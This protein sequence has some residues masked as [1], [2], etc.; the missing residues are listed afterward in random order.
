MKGEHAVPAFMHL[1]KEGWNVKGR[2][3]L[4]WVVGA[5]LMCVLFSGIQMIAGNKKQ[6]PD[7]K[8][9]AAQKPVLVWPL[10]PDLPRVRWL[11]E[12]TDMARVDKPAAKKHGWLDKLTGARTPDEKRLELQKPY[13]ITTDSRGRMYVA[14]TGLGVVFRVDATARVVDLLGGSTRVPMRMPVGVATDAEDRLFVS[15]ALLHSISCFSAAG[16]EIANFG[17]A[18]LG[19]PGGIAIDRQRNRLYAADA[20]ENRIAVFDIRKFTLLGY[21]GAMNSPKSSAEGS[22]AGPTNVAVDRRG[23]IYVADTLNCRIQ[24]LDPAG[25]I[26]RVF[27]TQGDRPGEFI[28]PKGIALD[29]EGHVYVADAEFNNFQIFSP[30]GHP[31]LAVGTFGV[32]PGEFGLIAGLHIDSRDRIYTTEMYIGRVQVFQYLVQPGSGGVKGG[33]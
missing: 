28:R 22:F 33:G 2:R 11:A 18:S 1:L 10:P 23:N 15:D 29:S 20:K 25:K 5:T 16:G 26:V 3:A 31:L 30:E 4:R 32:A 24:V 14:D 12:Y 13:G 9:T 27:G 8:G 21:F 17:A 7:A 19:R 6:E